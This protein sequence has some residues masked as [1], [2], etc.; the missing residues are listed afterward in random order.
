MERASEAALDRA[1]T[2]FIVGDDPDA[3]ADGIAPYVER[4]GFTHLVYHLPGDDQQRQMAAFC[5][6]VL[7]RLRARWS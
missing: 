1:H 5:D 7:P 2:R 4:H 6:D 3:I